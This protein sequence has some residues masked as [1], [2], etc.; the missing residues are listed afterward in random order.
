MVLRWTILTAAVV[1]A[2]SFSLGFFGP[3]IFTP[4]SNQGP[5]LGVFV[6]GPLGVVAG[7]II[8]CVLGLIKKKSSR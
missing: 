6:T 2:I 8:G 5:L 1:G 7:A 3:M 4:Q